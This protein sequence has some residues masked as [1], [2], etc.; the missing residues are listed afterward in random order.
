MIPKTYFTQNVTCSLFCGVHHIW[1]NV[2]SHPVDINETLKVNIILELTILLFHF[3]FCH[4]QRSKLSKPSKFQYEIYSQSFVSIHS[5]YLG[6]FFFF[7]FFFFP[8]IEVCL[9]M[10]SIIQVSSDNSGLLDLMFFDGYSITSHPR[11]F[12]RPGD[13]LPVQWS[14][15]ELN[16]H[17]T[18]QPLNP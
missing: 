3:Y 7:F 10:L 13:L 6:F 15:R 1:E 18:R 11:C 12:F 2:L 5:N 16:C 8:E 14:M 9:W 4:K 17:V